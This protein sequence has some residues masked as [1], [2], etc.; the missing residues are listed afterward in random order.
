MMIRNNRKILLF[1][2]VILAVIEISHCNYLASQDFTFDEDNDLVYI[3]E[4]GFLEGGQFNIRLESKSVIENT[5]EPDGTPNIDQTPQFQLYGC[6]EKE[7]TRNRQWDDVCFFNPKCTLTFVLSQ[8]NNYFN[9]EIKKEG[10][11]YFLMSKCLAQ[12][13]KFNVEYSF[14]N[15]TN[16]H[17]SYELMPLPII[18]MVFVAIWSILIIYWISNWVLNRTQHIKLHKVITLYPISKLIDVIYS[19]GYYQY[20]KTHGST[21]V[22]T[23]IMYWVIFIIFRIISIVVLLLISCGWSIL[24]V[25]I[26]K[27]FQNI[28]YICIVALAI[29]LGIGSFLGGYYNILSFIIYIPILIIIFIKTDKS[30]HLIQISISSSIQKQIQQQIQQ[31]EQQQQQVGEG[32]D[33]QQQVELGDEQPREQVQQQQPPQHPIPLSSVNSEIDRIPLEKRYSI[34]YMYIAFKWIML[35]FLGFTIILQFMAIVF[36]YT[37]AFDF[38][39]YVIEVSLFLCLALTFRLRKEKK[40]S[41]FLFDEDYE[42][43]NINNSRLNA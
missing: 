17:L 11:Y 29:T 19:L 28:I 37:W 39:T 8:G 24:P 20:I 16:N 21:N 31:Q 4:F 10:Y 3:A 18:L 23:L 35:I 7:F 9:D 26:S 6:F 12:E 43:D 13:M 36:T 1:I 25:S 38:F 5:T 30:I 32:D 27:S 34:L 14:T 15:P 42:M 22:A 2:V 41:Y 33:D 40:Q